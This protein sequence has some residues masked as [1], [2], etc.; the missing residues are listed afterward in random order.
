MSDQTNSDASVIVYSTVGCAFCATEK[1]WLDKLG[2]KYTAK[3]IDE[4]KDAEAELLDK[5][6]GTYQGV[7]TTIINGEVIVGFNRPALQTALAAGNLIPEA[8]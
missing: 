2:V 4:D 1:Q 7:P 6:D 8:A 5:L 3:N